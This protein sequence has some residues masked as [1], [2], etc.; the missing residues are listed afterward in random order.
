MDTTNAETTT[1]STTQNID[2]TG[3]QD[4]YENMQNSFEDYNKE[5]KEKG[6]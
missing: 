2:T 5:M 4:A 6:H 3:V 1:S